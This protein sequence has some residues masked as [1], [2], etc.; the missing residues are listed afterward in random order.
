MDYQCSWNVVPLSLQMELIECS[1]VENNQ[2]T[3][4]A[5]CSSEPDQGVNP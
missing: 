5:V 1:K 2:Q 4:D 3:F